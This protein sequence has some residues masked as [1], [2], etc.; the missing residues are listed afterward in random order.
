MI[1]NNSI[2]IFKVAPQITNLRSHHFAGKLSEINLVMSLLPPN[3]LIGTLCVGI[4]R[5]CEIRV[6]LGCV[7]VV[8]RDQD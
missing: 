2:S 4:E 6:S 3:Y 1:S 5:Q 8:G 7:D